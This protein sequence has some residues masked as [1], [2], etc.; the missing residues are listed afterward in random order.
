MSA[1]HK[2]DLY[3]KEFHRNSHAIFAQMRAEDPI[4]RQAGLDGETPI[5]FVSRYAEV[6]QIL[7]DDK[8][9]VRDLGLA[10]TQEEV[11]RIFGQLDPQ[12]DQMMNNHMLNRDGED[13]RRLRSLVSKAF[14]PRVIQSM[15][16][17]IETIARDLLDKVAKNGRMELVS[18]YAFPLPI[19]V[20]AELLGIPLHNQDQFRIWSNAFVMPAITPEEKQNAMRLLLEFAGYMQQLV[21]ERRRQPQEDLLSGLIHAE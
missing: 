18:E 8:H 19:T 21:A 13:H 1:I 16:P 17:R 20:I 5:W 4:F 2:Y 14:T 12:V 9:F 11:D 15:R 7:L 6:Q 3:S 10:L